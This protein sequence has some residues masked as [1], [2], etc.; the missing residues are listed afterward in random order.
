M[1]AT[2]SSVEPQI[3]KRPATQ[4][5]IKTAKLFKN[6]RSQAVRLPK[7]FRFEG[8]EVAIR[9]DPITGEVVLTPRA[10]SRKNRSWAEL[11]ADWDALGP[12]DDS[13]LERN[14][15]PPVERDFF[16]SGQRESGSEPAR[17]LSLPELY[18]IF[19]QADFPEDFFKREVSMPRE[20]DLF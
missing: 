17:K 14:G 3:E 15:A 8:K 19:D 4:P 1:S 10:E 11:F 12:A 13:P 16:Q 18:A 6:G 7:E 2:N 9:R 5:G 20:L